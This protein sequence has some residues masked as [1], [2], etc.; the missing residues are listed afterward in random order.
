MSISV[1]LSRIR[2][3]DSV[4]QEHIGLI[5]GISNKKISKWEVGEFNPTLTQLI[6]LSNFFCVPIEEIIGDEYFA[7][8]S[9]RTELLEEEY[10]ETFDIFGT[11]LFIVMSPIPY[12]VSFE[13]FVGSLYFRLLICF[14]LFL[15]LYIH[16]F[17][18][19]HIYEIKDDDNW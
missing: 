5:L 15:I 8:D 11:V 6:D 4:T 19:S 10:K 16:L 3:Y 12:F 2:E 9:P 7:K 18:D 13:I 17:I 14:L 1:L